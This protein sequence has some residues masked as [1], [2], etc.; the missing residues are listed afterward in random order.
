LSLTSE[1]VMERVLQKV[2]L[3]RC[4]EAFNNENITPDIVWKIS[5]YDMRCVGLS[6]R[7]EIMKLR[8]AC[9]SYGSTKPIMEKGNSGVVP[10]YQIPKE[11]LEILINIGFEISEIAQLL[12]VS[13]STVY[14]RMR[15]FG[16]K[17]VQ[18]TDISEEELVIIVNQTLQEFPKCGERMLIEILRQKTI[19]V[20]H[21][22][23]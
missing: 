22:P 2:G 8:T 17:K 14:R 7:T 12:S 15:V 18:F 10:S 19:K 21:L 5:L 11:T 3:E 16:L 13:E 23:Y 4:I 6:N 9:V 1:A 20:I